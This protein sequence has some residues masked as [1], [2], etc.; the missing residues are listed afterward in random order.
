MPNTKQLGEN[1]HKMGR[2]GFEHE[3]LVLVK[4]YR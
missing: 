3:K 2:A 4:P 1:Q